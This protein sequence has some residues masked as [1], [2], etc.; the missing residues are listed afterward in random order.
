MFSLSALYDECEEYF[1]DKVAVLANN[2]GI[3]T[4]LGWRKC[5]DV[6]IVSK[7]IKNVQ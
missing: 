5:M 2:A 3:N 7:H 1:Q 6:N 4:N